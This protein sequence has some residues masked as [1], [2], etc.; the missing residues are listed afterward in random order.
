MEVCESLAPDQTEPVIG[1]RAW[2]IELRGTVSPYE[3]SLLSCVKDQK[4]YRWPSGVAEAATCRVV[5][6]HR[7]PVEGCSCGFYAFR[8]LEDLIASTKG[9]RGPGVIG[10]VELWGKVVVADRG[11]RAQY[12]YPRELFVATGMDPYLDRQFPALGLEHYGTRV[13]LAEDLGFVFDAF[14]SW[15]SQ[16]NRALRDETER[17]ACGYR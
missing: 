13:R 10:T 14:G 15:G 12:A 16:R 11:F 7:A 17:R 9:S 1:W 5:S 6:E 8:R 3:Y 4:I 2:L